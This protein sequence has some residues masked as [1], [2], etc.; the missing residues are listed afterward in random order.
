MVIST[1]GNGIFKTE[2]TVQVI[3]NMV[4]W[5]LA[6]DTNSVLRITCK[7]AICKKK[8]QMNKIKI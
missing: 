8:S 2:E 3:G 5:H 7:L 1:Y 6:E 4:L